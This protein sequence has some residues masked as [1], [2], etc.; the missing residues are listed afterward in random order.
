MVSTIASPKIKKITQNYLLQQE[1]VDY[2]IDL[3]EKLWLHFEPYADKNFQSEMEQDF[4]ARFWEMY[5]GNMLLQQ[6]YSLTP[7]HELQKKGPDICISHDNKRIWIEAT[8]AGKGGKDII[9]ITPDDEI[10]LRYRSLIESKF[11]KYQDYQENIIKNHEA[12]VIAINT[13]RIP[14]SD[15][16]HL[17]DYVLPNIVKAVLPFGEFKIVVNGDTEKI[18]NSGYSH[19]DIINT[20]KGSPVE[21]NIFLQKKYE[22]IS[23]ILFSNMSI[24]AVLKNEGNDFIFVH[25]PM[26]KNH[27]HQGWLEFKKEYKFSQD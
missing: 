5:L 19:R 17:P 26:A 23:G 16:G 6:G 18:I 3:L 2:A 1:D 25:N 15:E 13:Y 8:A 12:Y 27:I 4:V 11:Q 24:E 22:G 9:S 7:R 14:F 21:T 20:Q 10:I